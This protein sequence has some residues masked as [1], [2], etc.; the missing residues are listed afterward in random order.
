VEE[1]NAAQIAALYCALYRKCTGEEIAPSLV[2][3]LYLSGGKCI[4][5]LNDRTLLKRQFLKRREKKQGKVG[6][7]SS[8]IRNIS[9]DEDYDYAN[10]CEN[11]WEDGATTRTEPFFAL[12]ETA[13]S[14]SAAEMMQ[15]WNQSSC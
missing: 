6:G 13:I 12:Y 3:R 14:Q 11:E 2:S 5:K 9:E 15:H 10:V 8:L 7:F 1:E 4:A